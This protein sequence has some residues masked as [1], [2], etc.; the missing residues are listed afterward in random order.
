MSV[1]FSRTIGSSRLNA[2]LRT[3]NTSNI[4]MQSIGDDGNSYDS[5][6]VD[7]SVFR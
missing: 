1:N 3:R 6:D 4:R 7:I 5:E 2:S